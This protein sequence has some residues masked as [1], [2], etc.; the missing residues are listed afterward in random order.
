MLINNH[1]VLLVTVIKLIEEP[2]TGVF[3]ETN[4]RTQYKI[5]CSNRINGFVTP[6]PV[7]LYSPKSIDGIKI[8]IK[9]FNIRWLKIG[10]NWRPRN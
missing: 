10:W 3:S 5:S 2:V 8:L 9:V 4:R 6:V 1:L 7:K